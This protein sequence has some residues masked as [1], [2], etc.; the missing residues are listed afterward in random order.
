MVLHEEDLQPG[1]ESVGR[2]SHLQEELCTPPCPQ[3]N[4]LLVH[5]RPGVPGLPKDSPA[6][7]PSGAGECLSEGP[8]EA[9]ENLA[10]PTKMARVPR[11]DWRSARLF[12][13]HHVR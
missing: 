9:S 5:F 3:R 10:W 12:L 11:I 1:Q 2:R 13:G 4:G 8:L 7:G 6:P